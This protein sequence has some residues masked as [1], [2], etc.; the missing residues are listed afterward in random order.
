MSS[1]RILVGTADGLHELDTEGRLESVHQPARS[2][3]ALAGTNAELWALLDGAE[4]VRTAGGAPWATVAR[5][6]ELR[7]HCIALTRAGTLIGTS[8]A[9]LLRVTET[10]LDELTAFDEVRGRPSWYTPWGDPPDTRSIA[11][12]GAAVYVNVHVGG[13]PR[14]RDLGGT[15]LPT[16]DV[17]ADVHQVFTGRGRV[18]AACAR[19]LAV[20][21]DGGDGWAIRTEGLHATYCRA[22]AICGETVLVSASTGPS[23]SNS[24]V[25]RGSVDG[26]TLE[27]SA[28]GL[29]EW[30]D[31]NIDT[32]CVDALPDGSLAA[33]ASADGR[34]FVSDDEGVSWTEVAASL[35]RVRCVLLAG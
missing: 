11:E 28:R 30:F 24:A 17:D 7:G 14:S 27:R 18:L 34:V 15:W 13:I 22:G 31:Q 32:H 2:V 20:S 3:V 4:V 16:I 8:Q 10:G 29:P 1:T 25:Y 19:G 33:F 23:G 26:G 9:R 12:D 21:E 6:D 35:P 5:L